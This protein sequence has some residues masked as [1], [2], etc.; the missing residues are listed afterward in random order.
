MGH[1]FQAECWEKHPNGC[2][3]DLLWLR[4]IGK[5]ICKGFEK[6]KRYYQHFIYEN[7]GNWE[8]REVKGHML[9]VRKKLKEN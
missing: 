8:K 3:F 1:V 2:S 4:E 6:E 5:G 7:K 9:Y